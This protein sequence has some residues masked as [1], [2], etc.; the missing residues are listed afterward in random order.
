MAGEY[1]ATMTAWRDDPYAFWL[2][3]AKAID[4]F[5]APRTAF[6]PKDG[7]YGRW[8][9]DAVCNTCWNAVDRHLDTRPDQLAIIHDSPLTGSQTK[10]TYRDL[11]VRVNAMAAVLKDFGIAKGDRV[12]IY[13]PMI[14]ETLV[15]M[16]ACARVGAIHSVVFGGF[17]ARELAARLD[18]AAPSLILAASCGIEPGRIVAYEP[19][20]TEATRLARERP[21]VLYF[22]RPERA[23]DL[24]AADDHD[25]GA[26]YEAALAAGRTVPCEPMKGTDPLYIL[27][28]S[29]TT[30]RPKGVVRD[31]AGHMV[32]LAWSMRNI[33]GIKPGEVFW[34]ASDVGWVVGHSYI[35]YAPLLHGATTL[36]YEGKPIGTPDANAFWRVIAEHKVAALFTAPTAIRAIKKEDPDGKLPA[37]HD[38][39]DFRALF[40]AGERADPASVAWA[41]TALGVPVIDH[42]WQTETGWTIVGNP[43]G[44]ELLPIKHGSPTKPMPGYDVTILSDEGEVLAPGIL[45]NVAIRLPL[46]PSCLPTLWGDDARFRSAYLDAFEGYYN[47]SDAGLIDDDGYVFIMARTDDV[48]NVAG[49]RLSTGVMED[50]LTSHPAIVE[51]AVI[52]ADDPIKGQVPVGFVVL[53]PGSA[54]EGLE[55]ELVAKVR[56]EV[57]PVAAFKHV[58]PVPRLPKTRSGKTLRA[59]IKKIADGETYTMPA[60]IDDPEALADIEI[61]VSQRGTTA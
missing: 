13:M 39:T 21:P 30:G 52:G 5:E 53:R 37:N 54:S 24:S 35:V 25:L 49:H 55:A 10:W 15:A 48:I 56:Q 7:P 16:L 50:V 1:A 26:L 34:A 8:F 22:Q 45:G 17:A 41:E 43:M 32:A 51:C 47:T 57:G 19:L 36:V 46:P 31:N 38:L 4:W 12:I 23:A 58:I 40:L 28:T 9:P 6:D 33:Y 29:G 18:D 42:W 59:T 44:L 27:Y 20:I 14:P 11:A 3:A 2:S 60:T 61:A